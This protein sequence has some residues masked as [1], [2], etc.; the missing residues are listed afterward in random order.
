M[1]RRPSASPWQIDV[2]PAHGRAGS[3]SICHGEFDFSDDALKDSLPFDL[4]ALFAFDWE[5]PA[6]PPV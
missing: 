4:E 1:P 2:L 6:A 5:F 3:T